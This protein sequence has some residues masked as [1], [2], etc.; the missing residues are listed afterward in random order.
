MP[1]AENVSSLSIHSSLAGHLTFQCRNIFTIKGGK[2]VKKGDDNPKKL[3]NLLAVSDASKAIKKPKK[4]ER[5]HHHKHKHRH[6]VK[7]E[8][9]ELSSKRST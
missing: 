2:V 4:E 9:K 6:E 1:N 7:D 8:K 5:H 3:D